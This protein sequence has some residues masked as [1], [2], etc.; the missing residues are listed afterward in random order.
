MKTKSLKT[1]LDARL[2]QDEL[3]HIEEAA[4]LEYQGFLALQQDISQALMEYMQ[5]QNLG[6]ND[7]VRQLGKSPTQVSLILQGKANLTLSSVAQIYALMH[8][9]PHL[10]V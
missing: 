8:K 4:Q 10:V 5:L 6:F 3:N 1:Y 9:V 7:V 2:N